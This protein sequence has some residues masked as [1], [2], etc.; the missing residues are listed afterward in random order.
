[1]MY[2]WSIVWTP[3][4]SSAT[5]RPIG[6]ATAGVAD[7][8]IRKPLAL[9]ARS[10]ILGAHQA[11]MERAPGENRCAF[12]LAQTCCKPCALH[13]PVGYFLASQQA[14]V[15]GKWHNRQACPVDPAHVARAYADT[16]PERRRRY[17]L[18]IDRGRSGQALPGV[19]A[20]RPR[21]LRHVERF[22]RAT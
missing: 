1:M 10:L 17:L 13:F 16:E 22:S 14:Q 8:L 3:R 12:V 9:S 15:S 21:L 2:S 19:F 11:E 20:R 5:G 6:M 7:R 4:R 18:R